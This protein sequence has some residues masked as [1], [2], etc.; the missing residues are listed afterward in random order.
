MAKS[1]QNFGLLKHNSIHII[2][3]E[4]GITGKERVGDSPKDKNVF[5]VVDNNDF[6]LDIILK[7][8]LRD[9]KENDIKDNDIIKLEKL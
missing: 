6:D 8:K 9:C 4:F 3:S 1:L 7:G 2:S 5:G